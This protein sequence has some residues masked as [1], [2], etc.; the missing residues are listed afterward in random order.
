MQQPELVADCARCAAL[1]C[2]GLAFDHSRHFAFD[3]PAGVPCRHLT[4]ADRCGIHQRL[5]EH[6]FGGCA[7]YDCLGAGQR[8]TSEVFPG[9]H[10]REGA[11]DADRLF[12]AFRVLR[13]VHEALQLLNSAARLPLSRSERATCT[14]LTRRLAP[15][16]PWT[17]QTLSELEASSVFHD[18]RGFLAAL[19]DTV[20][21]SDARKR[22]PLVELTVDRGDPPLHARGVGRARPANE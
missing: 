17:E 1:C 15:A 18:V 19:K 3:K 11:P 22:L 7:R 20:L 14:R 16:T 5:E 10:W 12:E 4:R 6:G 13:R 2:V 21:R 8:V 9:R